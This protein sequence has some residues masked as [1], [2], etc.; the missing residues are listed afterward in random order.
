VD[1][2]RASPYSPRAFFLLNAD[3][4]TRDRAAV[5]ANRWDGLISWYPDCIH[6][7]WIGEAGDIECMKPGIF[8]QINH[9]TAKQKADNA[10]H[11]AALLKARSVEPTEPVTI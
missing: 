4:E 7:R 3:D 9:L 2:L 5:L 11:D 8:T 1:A 6:P 10:E